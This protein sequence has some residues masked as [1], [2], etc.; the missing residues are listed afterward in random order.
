MKLIYIGSHFY[1]ESGTRMSCL[2][3]EDGSR[4]DW[5]HVTSALQCGERV[6][7]RP[8]NASEYVEYEKLL[9]EIKKQQESRSP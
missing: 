6:S 1:L 2:Y 3:T 7:I 4:S 9:R 5:N 8:A